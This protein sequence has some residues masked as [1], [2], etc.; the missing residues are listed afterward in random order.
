MWE[1]EP[2]N[3]DPEGVA[4]VG[5]SHGDGDFGGLHVVVEGVFES[6][7]MGGVG[8]DLFKFAEE[9]R[10]TGA[11]GDFGEEVLAD[12]QF[13]VTTGD[14]SFGRVIEEDLPFAVDL[15]GS[16]REF[17]DFCGVESGE[18]VVDVR[19]RVQGSLHGVYIGRVKP[20]FSQDC[21]GQANEIDGRAFFDQMGEGKDVVNR[22]G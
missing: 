16:A 21:V 7:D 11:R 18:D 9:L 13:G 15:N 17:I 3:E 2:G 10:G 4:G 22:Q 5:L 8:E 19:G 6:G 14:L 20:I 12:D 1:L